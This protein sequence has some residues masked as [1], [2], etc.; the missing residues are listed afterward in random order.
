MGEDA[1][2]NVLVGEG[3]V[4]GLVVE[5]DEDGVVGGVIVLEPK[6]EELEVGS[7]SGPEF[8]C[9]V[10]DHVAED[11]DLESILN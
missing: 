8:A 2:L 10:N 11:L 4:A 1:E 3:R 5:G 9:L 6:V 7:R